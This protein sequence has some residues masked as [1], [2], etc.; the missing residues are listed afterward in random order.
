MSKKRR[1][2]DMPEKRVK[3]ENFDAVIVG[4]GIIGLTVALELRKR[5]PF[6]RIVILEKETAAGRH[7]SGRNSGVLHSGIYYPAS[8]LKARICAAGARRMK[9]FAQENGVPCQ[10]LGK[11]IIATCER[12]F[13]AL[14]RLMQNARDN[15]IAAELLTAEEIKKIEPCANPFK[16][17]IYIRD[18]AVTDAHAVVDKLVEILRAKN[19]EIRFGERAVKF[20]PANR[21]VR[22]AGGV[23][24]YGFLF[25]C[26]GAYAD[27]VARPF[28]LGKRYTLLPF[29]GLYYQ[30]RPEKNSM[31]KGNIYPVPNPD[32]PFLGV[33]LTRVVD[34]TVYAGPTAIPAL[35]RENYGLLSGARPGECAQ[36][37][38]RLIGMYLKNHF[39]FRRLVH[40]ETLNHFKPHFVSQ[41]R[42]LVPELMPQDFIRASKVGIRPQLINVRE[43][44]LQMDFVIEETRHSIH[45]L[46]AI[47]P[48]FTCSLTFAEMIVDGYEKKVATGD[49]VWDLKAPPYAPAYVP[50][51][52]ADKDSQQ[53]HLS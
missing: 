19:V 3:F 26:A 12:D 18:T 1:G 27:Q 4:A 49:A 53:R 5:L 29:K 36:I 24:E 35:G 50:K 38:R 48:A 52:Y 6:A 16:K 43:E 9:Q 11:V 34:G 10:T 42:R 41:A 32:M 7:A 28:G 46:N 8:T 13:A 47:S 14:E 39:G 2:T 37:L 33:H 22:T 45:V 51:R 44:K 30:I 23:Y 21:Q 31:V 15:G 17:G 25:N 20:K 40:H